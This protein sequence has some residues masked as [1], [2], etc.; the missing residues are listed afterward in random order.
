MYFMFWT[1]QWLKHLAADL[2]MASRKL[3][4]AVAQGLKNGLG[5]S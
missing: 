3:M 1:W 4:Q 5:A 2:P